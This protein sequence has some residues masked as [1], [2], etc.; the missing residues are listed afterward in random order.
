M[1]E[2]INPEENNTEVVSAAAATEV[3]AEALP[4]E[5][6]EAVQLDPEA[7]RN[8]AEE[9]AVVEETA[10]AA[11]AAAPEED[12]EISGEKA[13]GDDASVKIAED[14]SKEA[15]DKVGE[16]EEEGDE[17]GEDKE[18][19]DVDEESEESEDS[20]DDDLPWYEDEEFWLGDANSGGFEWDQHGAATR[21]AIVLTAKSARALSKAKVALHYCW[22]PFVIYLGMQHPING[23]HLTVRDVLGI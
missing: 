12:G 2:S 11:P 15:E 6:E 14:N 22:L 16:D 4:E 1:S 13:Q 23:K 5:Q 19:D 3:P 10:A 17:D 9:V 20:D 21:A 18:D 8:P 7:D